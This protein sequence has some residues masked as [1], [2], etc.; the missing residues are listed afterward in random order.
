MASVFFDI[1]PAMKIVWMYGFQAKK[2][3]IQIF[4]NDFILVDA[5]I[6]SLTLNI[7]TLNIKTLILTYF[8]TDPCTY[9]RLYD[10][11]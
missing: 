2:A 3:N 8:K 7:K 9:F 5:G 6:Y 1:R 4:A 11:V 10:G